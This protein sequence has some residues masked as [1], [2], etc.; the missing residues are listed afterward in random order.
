MFIS[1]AVYHRGLKSMENEEGVKEKGH[2][3][4]IKTQKIALSYF[5]TILNDMI[6]NKYK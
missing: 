2:L 3:K 1:A 5:V 6:L 4:F